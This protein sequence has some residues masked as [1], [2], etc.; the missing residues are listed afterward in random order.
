IKIARSYAKLKNLSKA[1]QLIAPILAEIYAINNTEQRESKLT[2]LIVSYA[3][4]GDFPQL[5][6]I[7]ANMRRANAAR[8]IAWL[9]IAG[10]ARKANQPQIAKQALTQMIADGKASNIRGNF[11]DRQDM[12]WSAEMRSLSDHQGYTP[13]LVAF[14]KQIA[15]PNSLPFIIGDLVQN[16]KFDAAQKLIPKPMMMQIDTDVSDVSEFWLEKIALE[17][18]KAGKPNQL[19]QRIAS[20]TDLKRLLMFA[21]ALQQGGNTNEADRLF[22]LAQSQITDSTSIRDRA[23]IASA[24]LQQPTWVNQAEKFLQQIQAQI[25]MEPDLTKRAS[26]LLSIQSEFINR[27][28]GINLRSRYFDLA[29]Q[30]N[31]LNHVDFATTMGERMLSLR[32]PVSASLFIDITGNTSDKK[33]E[34]S[35][36]VIEM[37]VSQG[38]KIRARSL[39]KQHLPSLISSSQNSAKYI[40]RLAMLLVQV[41]DVTTAQDIARLIKPSSESDRLSERLRCY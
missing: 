7:M 5:I 24:L 21:E 33:L 3:P 17:A 40:E 41:G 22:N 27:Q 35:L 12:Q 29:K 14:M 2:V 30:L 36:Q 39:L 19:M 4:S 11:D 37:T 31:I 34:F 10:E 28:S 8:A 9:A 38:D 18:A 15:S 1:T 20:E 23:A 6:S 26:L 16:Q 13:E 25:A 32:D